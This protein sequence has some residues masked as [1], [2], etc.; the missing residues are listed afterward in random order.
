M[1]IVRK[2]IKGPMWLHF[3][4]GAPPVIVL[5]SA[6]A[7]LAGGTVPALAQLASSSYRAAVH[8][9]QPPQAQKDNKMQK[10]TT[11]PL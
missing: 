11:S 8:S 1:P 2:W 9:S 5:S 6:C 4:V 3:L 10:S 7:G